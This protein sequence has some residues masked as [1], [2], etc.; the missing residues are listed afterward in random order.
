MRPPLYAQ[1]PDQARIAEVRNTP[2]ITAVQP[3]ELPARPDPRRVT[4]KG[5]P[6]LLLGGMLG[7]F[8]TSARDMMPTSRKRDPDHYAEF[9]RLQRE[10]VDELRGLWRRLRGVFR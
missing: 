8:W 3:P 1:V 6:G 9:E 4:L 5:G 2:V 7:V 10:T